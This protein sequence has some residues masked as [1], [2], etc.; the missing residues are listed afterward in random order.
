[1][2]EVYMVR[3]LKRPNNEATLEFHT[4]RVEDNLRKCLHVKEGILVGSGGRYPKQEESE[5][6]RW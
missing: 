4:K 3:N 1:M 5:A 6:A 2:K